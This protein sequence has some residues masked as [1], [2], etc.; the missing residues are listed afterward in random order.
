MIK[1]IIYEL[2][3]GNVLG[4]IDV[5]SSV[6]MT[7]GYV[8]AVIPRGLITAD[9][10]DETNVSQS[11]ALLD[12]CKAEIIANMWRV[13]D[14]FALGKFDRN[15]RERYAAWLADANTSE[16]KKDMIRAVVAWSDRAW[17]HYYT[18]KAMVEAG[19]LSARFTFS[20]EIPYT[21]MDVF[22]A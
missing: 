14:E 10:N 16:T 15:E 9:F 2:E 19:D 20:E 3:T 11:V 4:T 18:K 12:A 17:A 5:T 21:F 7:D 1:K 6:K 22:N 13:S 8:D